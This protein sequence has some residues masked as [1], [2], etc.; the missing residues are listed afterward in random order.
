MSSIRSA[1]SNTKYVTLLKFVWWDSNISINLPG[2]AI[3]ISTPKPEQNY[4]EDDDDDDNINGG[5]V[6]MIK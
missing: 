1:S 3:T 2:V 6:A 4:D 5:G